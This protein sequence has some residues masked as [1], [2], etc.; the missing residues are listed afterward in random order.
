[1]AG[2][3]RRLPLARTYSAGS[4]VS[5]DVTS[6]VVMPN[7]SYFKRGTLF[8]KE[9]AHLLEPYG[10]S[11]IQ[12]KGHPGDKGVDLRG[13]F[14]ICPNESSSSVVYSVVAQC[15]CTKNKISPLQ[16]RE[17]E[18]TLS[19]HLKG[20][21]KRIIGIFVSNTDM[22]PGAMKGFRSSPHPTAFAKI[23]YTDEKYTVETFLLNFKIQSIIPKLSVMHSR[24]YSSTNDR[25][26]QESVLYGRVSLFYDGKL[27]H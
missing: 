16:I 8:E 22:T 25:N 17:F 5:S 24:Q 15:K 26:K 2:A 13:Y 9:A 4:V 20:K 1:M 6:K 19:R 21:D 14:K 3:M 7:L 10:F 12:L 18:G 11:W 27:I 23:N